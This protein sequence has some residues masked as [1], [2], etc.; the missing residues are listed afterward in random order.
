[1][2]LA[3]RNPDELAADMRGR[4]L[5]VPEPDH[6]RLALD[7]A[8]TKRRLDAGETLDSLSRRDPV[9][10]CA[11]AQQRPL[12]EHESRMLLARL[13]RLEGINDALARE[14][15]AERTWARTQAENAELWGRTCAELGRVIGRIA[16]AARAQHVEDDHEALV[17]VVARLAQAR[18]PAAKP[19]D[20]NTAAFVR[21]AAE[22]DEL[23]ALART[24]A[25]LLGQPGLEQDP[26]RLGA[27]L[28][29]RMAVKGPVDIG[30]T[31]DC[32]CGGVCS[33][34][35]E[36]MVCGQCGRSWRAMRGGQP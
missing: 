6:D 14:R 9:A 17:T 2:T 19:V 10:L 11:L 16:A 13:S 22:L 12:T 32:N 7:L 1:M 26:G 8:E 28:V 36:R 33:R 4:G 20:P 31:E 27:L 35:G 23:R 3:D 30:D 29:E 5:S 15:D 21:A 18:L 34:K 25:K 24:V